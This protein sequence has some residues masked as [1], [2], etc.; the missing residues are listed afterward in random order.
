MIMVNLLFFFE[1][2]LLLSTVKTVVIFYF[3]S[4]LFPPGVDSI[5]RFLGL[6]FFPSSFR[7]FTARILYIPIYLRYSIHLLYVD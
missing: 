6:A 3:I 1:R 7:W 2:V 4:A 5:V